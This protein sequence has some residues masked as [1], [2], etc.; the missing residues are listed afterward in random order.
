V[1]SLRAR[2]VLGAVVWTLVMVAVV[3]VLSLYL[4]HRFRHNY[5]IAHIA[6]MIVV[7]VGLVVAALWAVQSGL[8]PLHLLRSRLAA[9]REERE[10]R[11][12][13]EY[14]SE[15]QPLVDDLNAL[16][17]DREQRVSRALAKAGDLAHGLKT[18]LA[19]LSQ[20]AEGAAREGHRELAETLL[21]QI[22][23]MRRRV[24]HHLAHARA[25]ASRAT[26]EA[27]SR[28]KDS[29]EGLIRTLLR[30]HAERS[31]GVHVEV[32]AHHEA[33][34]H[35]GDLDEMLGN[36]LDN[37]CK[38]ARG[39]VSLSSTAGA[40][41]LTLVVDDDGPGL[42]PELRSKVLERGVRADEAAPGTGFGLAIVRD[43]AEAYGGTITLDA[44]PQGGV[45]AV[46]TLPAVAPGS[47]M[48]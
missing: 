32:P 15:V 16:L 27:R 17:E 33:R 38:W 25:A 2:L 1:R 10:R 3:N 39:R 24:D 23:R 26:P 28:V 19:V 11:V 9:L 37:A 48:L 41:F 35:P 31:I 42:D 45:R 40:G 30:L 4:V 18:P 44:S 36:V 8:A 6:L 43:L 5:G 13:G 20:E 12:A 46:L 47:G 34:V 7:A 14:P 22:D 21:H 29:A